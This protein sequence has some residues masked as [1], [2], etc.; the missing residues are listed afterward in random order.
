MTAKGAIKTN[1]KKMANDMK[2]NV[3]TKPVPLE[4][5][6]KEKQDGQSLGK[7]TQPGSTA[8]NS[9][10]SKFKR[11]FLTKTSYRRSRGRSGDSFH[12]FGRDRETAAANAAATRYL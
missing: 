3:R 2:I 4:E 12:R 5:V 11:S 8:P 7:R 10:S 1:L 6:A 9:L